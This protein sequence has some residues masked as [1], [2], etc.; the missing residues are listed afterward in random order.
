[1]AEE[2]G[3]PQMQ[4]SAPPAK[5]RRVRGDVAVAALAA[6]KTAGRRGASK[7]TANV[8]KG[9]PVFA[10][11]LIGAALAL[12]VV[13]ALSQFRKSASTSSVR[14]PAATPRTAP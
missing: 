5:T 10:K 7:A 8:E 11:V 14:E 3:L 1:M 6:D 2:R 4:E 13:Y 12:V 9:F